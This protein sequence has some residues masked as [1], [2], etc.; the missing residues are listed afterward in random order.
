MRGQY[1]AH[2]LTSRE[3]SWYP[4]NGGWW[5]PEAVLTLWKREKSL[6]YAWIWTLDHPPF[7]LVTTLTAL[8]HLMVWRNVLIFRLDEQAEC[9][10]KW[11]SCMKR[12]QDHG[13]REQIGDN[14]IL[15][16]LSPIGP[17]T[18]PSVFFL[19]DF[20]NAWLHLLFNKDGSSI[21]LWNSGALSTK[22]CVHIVTQ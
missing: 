2:H 4:M 11:L 3:E 19:T 17:T 1:R 5:A 18:A 20:F 15:V 8:T 14:H 12:V 6:A 22:T 16:P 21:L 13:C 7:G 9:Q 10:R